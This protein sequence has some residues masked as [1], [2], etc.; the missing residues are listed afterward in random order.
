[1]AYG[2]SAWHTTTDHKPK[3]LAKCLATTQSKCLRIV[4]G[5]YR[6][7]PVH[8]LETELAVPPLD[9]CLNKRAASFE[10]QLCAMQ[11]DKLLAAW[12][13]TVSGVSVGWTC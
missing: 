13:Q 7:T 11:K 4:A 2:A 9:L 3:R 6:A 10:N 12:I 8:C 5:A 1:M